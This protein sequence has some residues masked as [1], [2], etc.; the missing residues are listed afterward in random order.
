MATTKTKICVSLDEELA[1][2]V[3]K[4][5]ADRKGGFSRW[6]NDACKKELSREKRRKGFRT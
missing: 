5:T 6:V 1:V 3:Q 2:L 4:L